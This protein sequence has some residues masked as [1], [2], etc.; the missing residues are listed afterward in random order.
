MLSDKLGIRSLWPLNSEVKSVTSLQI[1]NS[2]IIDV[3]DFFF[4]DIFY[5]HFSTCNSLF[6]RIPMRFLTG[7]FSLF[8]DQRTK[9]ITN[10]SRRHHHSNQA[11][12]DSDCD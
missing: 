6:V 7:C 1:F 5:F 3:N 4:Y 2:M 12:T 8:I 10:L 9:T 11:G